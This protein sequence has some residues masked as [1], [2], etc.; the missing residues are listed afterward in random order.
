MP[1]VPKMT[2]FY[3]KAKQFF[4]S[5][6]WGQ[7][8]KGAE[9]YDEPF[10]PDSWT[11]DELLEHGMQEAVDLTHYLVGL[12]DKIKKLEEERF[13]LR[14]RVAYLEDT[15]KDA[16]EETRRLTSIIAKEDERKEPFFKGYEH[17]QFFNLD[18]KP[19]YADI[20]D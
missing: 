8:Q 11:A 4:I 9:K 10:D 6:Q 15:R 7:I 18:K 17:R 3:Q 13:R 14:Q 19:A 5:F 2:P 1:H 16:K 12:H 20:D